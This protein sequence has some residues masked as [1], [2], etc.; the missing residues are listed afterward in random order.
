LPCSKELYPIGFRAVGEGPALRP[1][2]VCHYLLEKM[3]LAGITRAYIVLR[4]GKWDIPAYL[5]DGK[6]VDMHLAYL[7]MDLPFGPPY[8][9]DQ[10]YPF[11]QRAVV[12]F[13]FPDILFGPD[14]AFARLL[15][16]RSATNADVVLGIMAA[17]DGQ[18]G[19]RVELGQD[20]WVRSVIPKAAKSPLPHVWICA[21]WSPTFTQFMHQHL[22]ETIHGQR[23]DQPSAPVRAPEELTVGHVLQAAL[24]NGL[25]VASVVF[26]DEAFLDIGT[27]QDLVKA[28]YAR[29]PER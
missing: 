15:E 25:R 13:G 18:P 22:V 24:D 1:K 17:E 5:G 23:L 4:E 12:A 10:A 21:V 3:R 8:T 26:A 28:V 16:R 29:G 11:V 9:V 19:D 14:D 6:L 27:P 7:M 2:V 20:G